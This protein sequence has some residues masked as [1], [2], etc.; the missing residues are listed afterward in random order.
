MPPPLPPNT[1]T[2]G[3]GR[4]QTP[5]GVRFNPSSNLGESTLTFAPGA[6]GKPDPSGDLNITFPQG[7]SADNTVVSLDGGATWS[8]FTVVSGGTV[9]P[10]RNNNFFKEFDEFSP[11]NPPRY[12]I[13]E[14]GGQQFIFFPDFRETTGKLSGNIFLNEAAIEV[15]VCFVAGTLIDTADGLRAVEDIVAGDLVRTRDNGFQPV[16]WIGRTMVAPGPGTWPVRITAGALGP[17]LP[18]RDLCVSPQH[19]VVVSG[20]LLLLATTLEEAL[21]PAQHL[22][23][24]KKVLRERGAMPI[25]YHHLLF[26]RHEVIYSEGAE[27]ESFHPGQWG[28][29]TLSKAAQEE[30]L[31]LFP[32]L[33][34]DP[35]AFG[36]SVI[37]ALRRHE[38]ICL[39]AKI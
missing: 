38:A 7:E 10:S 31:A 29:G 5:G 11:G 18:A 8:S 36:P 30:L 24:G 39:I 6:N 26:D 32:E 27:T 12:L 14:I 2:A 34:A 28:I 22:V 3:S 23:D 35:M 33:A 17:G 9:A 20:P 21:V 16:R 25:S 13:L 37:P 15:V 4:S 19:R 1:F